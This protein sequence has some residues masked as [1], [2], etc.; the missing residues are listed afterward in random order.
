MALLLD[1]DSVKS[2]D[3]GVTTITEALKNMGKTDEEIAAVNKELEDTGIKLKGITKEAESAVPALTKVE[4]AAKKSSDSLTKMYQASR[5]LTVVS[6]TLTM[7]GGA[8]VGGITAGAY[9]YIAQADKGLKIVQD[10]NRAQESIAASSKRMGAVFAQAVLPSIQKTAKLMEKIASILE[11]NPAWVK[12]AL[13][14]GQI[15]LGLGIAAKVIMDG[16]KMVTMLKSLNFIGAGVSKMVGGA[17]TVV[18]SLMT[19]L[20]PLLSKLAGPLAIVVGAFVA[21]NAGLKLLNVSWADLWGWLKKIVAF[22]G[23]SLVGAFQTLYEV[24]FQGGSFK[25]LEE[26][27]I[28]GMYALDQLFN[29]IPVI[30]DAAKALSTF[31]DANIE[32]WNK[33]QEE[34]SNVTSEYGK[35][36]AEIERSSNEARSTI[37]QNY[38]SQM[39]DATANY[40]QANADAQAQYFQ[41]SSEAA[42][43]FAQGQAQIAQDSARQLADLERQY[44]EDRQRALEDHELRQKELLESRDGLAMMHEDEQ[45]AIDEKRRTE[46][47]EQGRAQVQQQA[48]QTLADNAAQYARERAQRAAEF[49]SRLQENARN[50]AIEKARIKAEKE[51]ALIELQEQQATAISELTESYNEQIAMINKSF[52]ERLR[53]LGMNIYNDQVAIEQ[54]SA[55]A[56]V[57]FLNWLQQTAVN[58]PVAGG[59]A[60]G[61]YAGYGRYTLGEQGTEF[62]LNNRSTKAAER[63]VNGNLTQEKL[64]NLISGRNGGYIDN[65]TL[66]FNN[67]TEADRAAIRR[68][69]YDVTKEVMAEGMA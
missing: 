59:M 37:L 56:H 30:E 62:V 16:L 33:Y 21:I 47:Y 67:M 1:K 63:A 65:R 42:S 64:M 20:L 24:L 40:Y 2:V 13:S 8:I 36:R 12:A 41:S 38:S 50:Y 48:A 27:M 14:V 53:A 49:I 43:A 18:P 26:N 23:G 15:M 54:A 25:N 66:Q 19:K 32:E 3:E 58:L 61:G 45:F 28:K 31:V 22:V 39:K 9:A 69:M 4:S 17:E 11:K 35:Q 34:I 57:A 55:R 10:W 46:D 44:Q 7:M 51:A 5:A 60:T 6:K 68:D 29:K 52:G